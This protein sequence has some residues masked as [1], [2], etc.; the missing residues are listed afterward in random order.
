MFI[1]V[2][3][4]VVQRVNLNSFKKKKKKTDDL[5]FKVRSSN[6]QQKK[7]RVQKTREAKDTGSVVDTIYGR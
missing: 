5:T 7:L 1:P 2:Y 6:S 3:K 4:R